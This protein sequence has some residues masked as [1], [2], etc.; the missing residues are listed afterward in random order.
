M[1]PPAVSRWLT[2]I[3]HQNTD[4]RPTEPQEHP[5]PESNPTDPFADAPLH[6]LEDDEDVPPRPEEDLAD[7]ERSEPD[8]K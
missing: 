4:N 1:P 7:V 3:L 2:R 6:V 8:P 5:V